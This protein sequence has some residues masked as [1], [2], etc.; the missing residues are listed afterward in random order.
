MCRSCDTASLEY[1]SKKHPEKKDIRYEMLA[2]S[3]ESRTNETYLLRSWNFQST[4]KIRQTAYMYNRFVLQLCKQYWKNVFS[5]S[6]FHI[7][8]C[9]STWSIWICIV[10]TFCGG[11]SKIWSC[12]GCYS[13]HIV[14]VTLPLT[15]SLHIQIVNHLI[16]TW[17]GLPTTYLISI[18]LEQL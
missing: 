14:W 13:G 9:F 17:I 11:D 8:A 15:L 12:S 18:L 10:E 16:F 6:C 7:P 5:E 1:V 3:K 2:Y 4:G